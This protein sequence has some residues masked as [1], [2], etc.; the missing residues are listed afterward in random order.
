MGVY[1]HPT[2]E[3]ALNNYYTAERRA[4]TDPLVAAERLLEF[5]K[6]LDALEQQDLSPIKQC[7][8]RTR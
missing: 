3:E 6:R 4:G 8:E 7:L 2:R 5:S 1:I